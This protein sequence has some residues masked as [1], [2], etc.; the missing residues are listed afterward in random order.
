MNKK[1]FFIRVLSFLIAAI[2]YPLSAIYADEVIL[3]IRAVNPLKKEAPTPI[4]EYLPKGATPNDIIGKKSDLAV[5]YDKE[6]G[7]YYVEGKMMLRPKEVLTL[8]VTIKDVWIIPDDKIEGMKNEAEGAVLGLSRVPNIAEGPAETAVALKDEILK[9][10]N[11]IT[12]R[13]KRNTIAKVGAERHISEYWEDI[14]SLKKA[15]TDIRMLKNL[16]AKK[17]ERTSEQ[18]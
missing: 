6:K 15:E 10:L 14:D 1:I 9:E 17:K 18:E 4:K 13:Q 5:D 11:K 3:K 16:L 2:L 8:E 7:L 12:E